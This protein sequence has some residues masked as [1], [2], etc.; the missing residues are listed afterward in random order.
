[1]AFS[2]A[3][4][5]RGALFTGSAGVPPADLTNTLFQ[6]LKANVGN[7]A[8]ETPALPVKSMLVVSITSLKAANKIK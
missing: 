2:D 6:A 7:V 1:M 4:V 8:G 3:A 5:L